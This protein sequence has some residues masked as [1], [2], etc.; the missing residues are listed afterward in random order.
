MRQFIAGFY[1]TIATI[2][3]IVILA[4]FLSKG[5]ATD[6]RKATLRYG[7]ADTLKTTFF[8]RD[9]EI[10]QEKVK[11]TFPNFSIVKSTPLSSGAYTLSSKIGTIYE[12]SIVKDLAIDTTAPKYV[13]TNK[14]K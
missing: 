10:L 11:E 8:L 6:Y 13:T 3:S 1:V 7:Y 5:C 9:K 12:L 2:A 4:T 14:L